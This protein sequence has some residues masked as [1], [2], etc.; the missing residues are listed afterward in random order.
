[1]L[2]SIG[3]Q[4]LA[5]LLEHCQMNCSCVNIPHHCLH[6]LTEHHLLY[7]A[8]HKTGVP[9]YLGTRIPVRSGLYINVWRDL[10]D[11]PDT[12]LLYHL[13][14]GWSHDYTGSAPPTHTL[15]NLAVAAK[16]DFHIPTWER[17]L[18]RYLV[19]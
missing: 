16:T 1:M 9:Y 13:E 10:L 4:H 7:D 12:L 15:K 5:I 6:K 18:F 3:L 17:F 2:L 11:F 8:V 19:L 14:F